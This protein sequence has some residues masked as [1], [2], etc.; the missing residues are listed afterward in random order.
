MK[1]FPFLLILVFGICL[2]SCSPYVI[3][4]FDQ[5]AQIEISKENAECHKTLAKMFENTAPGEK[6]GLLAVLSM[7]NDGNPLCG[8]T[9]IFDMQSRI[10]ESRDNMTAT[11]TGQA[12]NFAGIGAGLWA[13]TEIIKAV[14]DIRAVSFGRD[15]TYYQDSANMTGD[16]N[17]SSSSNTSD[18]SDNSD[19][20]SSNDNSDDH[21][22]EGAAE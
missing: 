11:V 10:A 18:Q 19:N 21:T 7:A 16:E 9:N 14:A 22:T 20:S 2:Q 12:F 1:N 17:S 3:S 8:S 4:K 13:G 5:Q 15:G 6:I